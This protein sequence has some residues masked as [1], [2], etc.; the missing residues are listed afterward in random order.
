MNFDGIFTPVVTPNLLN[1]EIDYK[2]LE[3][4]LGYLLDS[5]VNGIVIAGT[6]GEYYAQSISERVNIIKFAKFQTSIASISE[7]RRS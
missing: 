4:M 6:T 1:L 7:L 5:K 3:V 2:G